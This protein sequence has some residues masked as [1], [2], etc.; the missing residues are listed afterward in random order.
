MFLLCL[1]G[2]VGV[3]SLWNVSMDMVFLATG[4]ATGGGNGSGSGSF[5]IT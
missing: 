1:G 2:F 5:T 4:G 3:I